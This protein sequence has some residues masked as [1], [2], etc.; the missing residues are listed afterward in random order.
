MGQRPST[1]FPQCQDTWWPDPVRS[2][3]L[4]FPRSSGQVGCGDHAVSW[5]AAQVPVGAGLQRPGGP[6]VLELVAVAASTAEGSE[7]PAG[8]ASFDPAAMERLRAERGLAFDRLAEQLGRRW[9][10]V[11]VLGVPPSAST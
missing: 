6:S 4:T 1:Q 3:N 11:I 5:T 2:V 7:L 8:V 9:P 10:N